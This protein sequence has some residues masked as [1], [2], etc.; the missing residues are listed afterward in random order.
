MFTP[1]GMLGHSGGIGVNMG[2]SVNVGGGTGSGN[3]NGTGT[4]TDNGDV[5]GGGCFFDGMRIQKLGGTTTTTTVGVV[6]LNARKDELELVDGTTVP[7]SEN[8]LTWEYADF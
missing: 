3:G 8:G 1:I 6:R 5:D 4:D 2:V 7:L